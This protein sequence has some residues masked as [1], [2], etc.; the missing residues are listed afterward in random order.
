MPKL[1]TER[2]SVQNPIIKYATQVGWT[3][4]SQEEA[5]SLR[6]GEGGQLFYDVLVERLKALNHGIVDDSNVGE[7][8]KKI[9]N[10]RSD[11]QGN[12]EVL[13]WLKGECTVFVN[14]Q[15]REL[16]VKVVDFDQLDQDIFQ[17]TDEWQYTNG[18]FT[19]RADIVFLINGIPVV[20]VE[21]K[22]A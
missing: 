11:I 9:E 6:K 1:P 14:S 8:V 18:R 22:A 3:K 5:L 16:N 20:L 4:V 19:N 10:V 7:I 17:V 21:T 2:S 13:R 15:R 12:R